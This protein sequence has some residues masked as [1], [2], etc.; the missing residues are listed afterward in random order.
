[1]EVHTILWPTDLSKNSIKAAKHVASLAEKYQA[2]V[3]LLYVGVDLMSFFPAYGSY[4]GEDQLKN[5][6]SWELKQAKKQ[7]ESVCDKELKAC[8]NIE[9]KLIQGDATTEILKTVKEAKADM[10]VLTSHG[11]GHEGLDKKS[12]DFG[13]VA[14]KVMANSPA[15]V[16]LVNPNA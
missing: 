2:K 4:P 1:M 3:I 6:Q 11:R 5:F 10:V 12:A 9:V 15:P 7:L 13:S 8:P 16:H 14:K